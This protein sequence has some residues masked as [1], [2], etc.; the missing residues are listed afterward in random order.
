MTN[1]QTDLTVPNRI[2]ANKANLLAFL[3]Y[4]G[5]SSSPTAELHDSPELKWSIT[6]M[7]F[8]FL[9]NVLRTQLNS[10]NVDARIAETLAYLREKN[11]PQL[12]WWVE[13]E[14]QPDDL[15]DHLVAQGL[16]YSQGGLPM[17][18][19]LDKL[20]DDIS[21]PP[22]L[23]VETVTDE[24]SLRRWIEPGLKGFG[25]EQLSQIAT[26]FELLAGLGFDLP[27]RLYVGYLDGKPVAVS[28]LFLHAG[29]AGIYWVATIPEVRGQ[30]IGAMLTLVPL[31]DAC[32]MGYRIGILQS[33]AMGE[34]VY[35]RLGFEPH[36]HFGIYVLAS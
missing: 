25:I 35:R 9:N 10:N 17:T 30:G 3:E 2:A 28:Q 20:N 23:T 5:T 15:A 24:E 4:V 14:S 32:E 22:G 34:S 16:K 33:S 36:P 6:G 13:A 8:A 19:D 26:G 11:I 27:L 18:V 29:V 1:I 7:P 12:C 21:V 31:R